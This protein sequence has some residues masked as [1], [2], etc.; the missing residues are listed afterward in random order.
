VAEAHRKVK[1]LEDLGV[2]GPTQHRPSRSALRELPVLDRSNVLRWWRQYRERPGE[3][4][5]RLFHQLAPARLW[6]VPEAW[7]NVVQALGCQSSPPSWQDIRDVLIKQFG[8]GARLCRN[9][10]KAI[11]KEKGLAPGVDRPA[12]AIEQVEELTGG[13][14]LVLVQAASLE[15]GAVSALAEGAVCLA[16]SKAMAPLAWPIEPE[17]AGRD[18]Q[19]RLT[20]DLNRNVASSLR[21]HDPPRTVFQSTTEAM[22][23]RDLSRQRV[24]HL[25]VG[26]ML[27]HLSALVALPL[28]TERR[29]TVGL[30]DP[31]G[32]W[33]AVVA[34]QDYMPA[35]L[36]KTLNGLKLLAAGTEL[37]ECHARTWQRVSARWLEGQPA[38]RQIV[39]YVDGSKD[40]WWTDR[41]AR[42]GKVARTGRVQPCLDRTVIAT[43][44]GV[45]LLADV[46]SGND[47]LSKSFRE[48]LNQCDRVL[49]PG[50]VGRLTVIDAACCQLEV[51][52]QFSADPTRNLVTV[53]KGPLARN[54]VLVPKGEW[55][56][57]R[58]REQIREATVELAP[59]K[60]ERLTMRAVEL[61]RQSS[62]HPHSTIFLSTA[63][64]TELSTSHVA[65]AYLCRWVSIEDR[66][67]VA[68]AGLGWQRTDG[69]GA[70]RVTHFAVIE[71]Q[72]TAA[73]KL[74]TA[75]QAAA[76]A[77]DNVARATLQLAA[78]EERVTERK[79][80]AAAPLS[81]RNLLGVR[82]AK[83][84]LTD[85]KKVAKAAH[86]LKEA[87]RAEKERLDSMPTEVY[88][89]DTFLDT[90]TA[91]LKMTLLCLLEFVCK[92]YLGGS[93]MEPRTLIAAWMH[94]PVTI[95]TVT[96]RR[97]YEVAPNPR[98][99]KK[100]EL[101]RQALAEVTRRGLHDSD[102]R[103]IVA[104]L[105]G[106]GSEGREPWRDSC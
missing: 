2:A 22:V 93:A 38:W 105:K 65:D 106:E 35:T 78:A 50:M 32:A 41:F 91:C 33:L 26:T 45:P 72:K 19:G 75:T 23:G 89:R 71:K 20:A 84:R 68:R 98:D 69:F 16:Q 18:A 46:E 52:R 36:E 10:I 31:G 100:T 27:R 34:G 56:P 29:G 70:C 15:T 28:V 39:A 101:L 87:V 76:T 7:R 54:K 79:A 40:A 88:V 37:W 90:I 51:L 96:G 13:G 86:K 61:V 67:R 57:Y 5:E 81:G 92:E 73:R 21:A 14:L 104:R 62:R 4:W 82:Q 77:T 43:G 12:G 25:E 59:G 66:F 85:R 1:V 99:P 94:L 6:E 49:G 30:Q 97:V 48:L 24:L 83:R 8:P 47:D 55:Q 11:L 74:G 53:L 17:P 80:K 60:P 58:E 42:S 102:G 63:N 3:P 95:H 64:T 103:L 9:T 44:A